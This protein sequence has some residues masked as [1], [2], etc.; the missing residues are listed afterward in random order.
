MV[1]AKAYYIHSGEMTC[2]FLQN[3]IPCEGLQRDFGIRAE[4]T[5]RSVLIW[6]FYGIIS[7]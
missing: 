4:L 3:A 6:T 1:A 5:T 2:R 7:T